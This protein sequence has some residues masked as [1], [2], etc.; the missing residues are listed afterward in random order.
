MKC[1]DDVVTTLIDGAFCKVNSAI[2]D[3]LQL[4]WTKTT[5]KERYEAVLAQP[6]L[7]RNSFWQA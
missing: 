1:W 3:R 4:L 5:D 2:S 6:K 7:E